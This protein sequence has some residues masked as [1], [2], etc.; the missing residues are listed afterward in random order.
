[1]RLLDLFYKGGETV[2]GFDKSGFGP[3]DL[4][5]GDALGGKTFWATTAEVRFPIPLI[6]DELGISGAVFADAGSLYDAGAT[7]KTLS[8]QCKSQLAA[9]AVAD[10]K[11]GV[12]LAD[13][14]AL[15]SS[16]GASVL[17]NSPLGPLRLDYAHA[18]SSDVNDK[19]KVITFGASTKF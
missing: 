13:S 9:G 17:W 6:P 8:T 5:T 12:C 7:A 10:K 16:I 3:R 1:V 15:R 18:L 19:T 11:V 14:N 2:R 4:V